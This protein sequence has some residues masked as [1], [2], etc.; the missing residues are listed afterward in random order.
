MTLSDKSAKRCLTTVAW[1]LKGGKTLLVK[2]KKLGIWLAPG[3]HVEENELPQ[4]AA[5][6]EFFE[7][8]GVRVQV[9]SAES[10][11][12]GTT[13]EYLP[14]PFAM[15]LHWINKP[16][17][18]R[19]FCEQHYTLNFFVKVLDEST[20]GRQEEETDDIGWFTLDEIKELETTDDIRGEAS[21]V[22]A[23]FPEK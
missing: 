3:G 22:F 12:E 9:I 19:G 2:H 13:S 1:T 11:P 7:E 17:K 8:T 5:E 21:Y 15:N 4:Q 23:H 14:T 20:F 18:T 16:S 10:I 6:R